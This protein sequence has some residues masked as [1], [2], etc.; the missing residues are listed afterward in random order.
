MW[1]EN[2]RIVEILKHV[3]TT[4]VAIREHTADAPGMAID[5][6]TPTVVLPM[7]RRLYSP[8]RR[9]PLDSGAVEHGAD[10]DLA[11]DG[12]FDQVHVDTFRLAESVRDALASS[13]QV[14]LTQ[15]V[16]NSPLEHGLAELVSYLGLSDD[17]FTTVFDD[18]ATDEISWADSDEIERVA[19]LPRTG[20][21]RRA[22][23]SARSG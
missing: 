9:T 21:V 16:G 22:N 5:E 7:E 18:N 23:G 10:D 11:T 12:L 13:S 20:F 2:K 15:L 3:S 14:S 8:K 4:A 19:T 1:L 6:T 17:T